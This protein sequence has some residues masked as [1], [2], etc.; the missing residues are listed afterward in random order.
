MLEVALITREE[1][2]FLITRE[3]YDFP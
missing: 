3:E 2:D 1:Y